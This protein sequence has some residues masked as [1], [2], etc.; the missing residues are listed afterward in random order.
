MA[1]DG[2]RPQSI[3]VAPPAL[4]LDTA[5]T[6]PGTRFTAALVRPPSAS[7]A[8]G[9]TTAGLGAPDLAL[10]LR[11]HAAYCAALESLG[12]RVVALPS[13]DAHPDSTFVEDT[14]VV[15]ALGA[16]VTRPGA[17]S[18]AGEVASIR[19]A[20]EALTGPVAA[21]AAPGTLDGGDVCQAGRHFFIGLSQRTSEAGAARL[22]DWLVGRGFTTSTIDIRGDRALLHLKSGIAWLGGDRM[23]V[24]DALA[25]H[26]DLQPYRRVVVPDA[27]AYAANCVRVNDAVLVPA[28][29][30]EAAACIGE[31][32]HRVV[33][34]DV[35]EFRKMDGGLSCLSLRIP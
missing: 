18:R 25:G 10:A 6:E 21:I 35:S 33:A 11:Q 3:I 31:L 19:P 29:F 24:T 16:I 17:P 2:H 34:L 27:E 15:T 32:G 28:G 30:P 14:A 12:V 5:M 26:A 1:E 20:L 13:D 4:T 9:L 23:V 8:D 22:A 7:F